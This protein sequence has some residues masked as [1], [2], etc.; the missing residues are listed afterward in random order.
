MVAHA[1]GPSDTGRVDEAAGQQHIR[2]ERD[3]VLELLD[4]DGPEPA[5]DKAYTREALWLK[6]ADHGVKFGG[7]LAN[8]DGDDYKRL[9]RSAMPEQMTGREFLDRRRLDRTVM[10]ILTRALRRSGPFPITRSISA[11]VWPIR[12]LSMF[13]WF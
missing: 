9:F 12:S 7:Y 5:E 6:N 10:N 3:Q 2:D 8:L 13:F 1:S 11:S 4:T